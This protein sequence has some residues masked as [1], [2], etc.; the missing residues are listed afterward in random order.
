MA[1]FYSLNVS[2]PQLMLNSAYFSSLYRDLDYWHPIP[3]LERPAD[4]ALTIIFVSSTHI[5]YMAP[6]YDPIFPAEQRRSVSGSYED[7]FYN[8]DTRA[9]PLACVDKSEICATDPHQCWAMRDV[10]PSHISSDPS[11]WLTKWSMENSNIYNA[12]G[13]RLG[14]ALL[15]QEKVSQYISTPLA[16]N[17]WEIEA[18]QLFATS[19]ARIQYDVRG[20]AVGE[21]RER[22]GYVEVT[23][24][25]ARGK[26]C[27]LFKFRSSEHTNVNLAAFLGYILLSIAIYILSLEISSSEPGSKSKVLVIG[28]I[29]MGIGSLVKALGGAVSSGFGHLTQRYRR[30]SFGAS[31]ETHA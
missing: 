4:S 25:E 12:I 21:D 8:A 20:I 9:R 14:A 24:D 6:S 2:D 30:Q 29:A 1:E 11:F 22:A 17:Q 27:G 3:E 26:L 31:A 5:Y 16:S 10:V 19:L 13:W 23:P 7:Y 18:S 15:A 28:V